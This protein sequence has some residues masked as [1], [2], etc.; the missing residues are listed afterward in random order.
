MKERQASERYYMKRFS[1]D[2]ISGSKC[3]KDKTAFTVEHPRFAE[4]VEGKLSLL[5]L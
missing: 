3:D 1:Q 2:W 4:L 5:L